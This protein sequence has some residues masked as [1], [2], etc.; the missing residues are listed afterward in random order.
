MLLLGQFDDTAP[1]IGRPEKGVG[2]V[3]EVQR[4]E[5]ATNVD[6]YINNTPECAS[7]PLPSPLSQRC[8]LHRALCPPST[9]LLAH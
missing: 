8:S 5:S 3:Y 2:P 1:V 9:L 6:G 7:R 4:S